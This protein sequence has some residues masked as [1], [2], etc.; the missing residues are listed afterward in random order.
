M[1]TDE[2]LQN[3]TADTA[4]QDTGGSVAMVAALDAADMVVLH[5]VRQVA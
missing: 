4:E 1:I 3:S 2:H 5:W